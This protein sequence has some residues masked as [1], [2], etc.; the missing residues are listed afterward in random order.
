METDHRDR[1][2]DTSQKIHQR[3]PFFKARSD[4]RKSHADAFYAVRLNE[5]LTSTPTLV[6]FIGFT[7]TNGPQP[8]HPTNIISAITGEIVL[9]HEFYNHSVK[10]HLHRAQHVYTIILILCFCFQTSSIKIG[11]NG[12]QLWVQNYYQITTS[13]FEYFKTLFS[14]FQSIPNLEN[15]K[16][17]FIFS[18]LSL[19]F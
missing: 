9:P 16:L 15:N 4:L 8:L 6:A 14:D 7:N 12:K 5:P 1:E 2:T 10:L 19:M 18:C 17:L 11:E 3:Q 13:S